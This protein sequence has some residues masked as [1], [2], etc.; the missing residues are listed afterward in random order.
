MRALWEFSDSLLC[1]L[2][3]VFK[4]CQRCLN[5]IAFHDIHDIVISYLA[6]IF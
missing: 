3:Q 2:L 4:V 6:V 5:S 1:F